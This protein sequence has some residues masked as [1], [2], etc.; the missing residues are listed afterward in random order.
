[1]INSEI[2]TGLSDYF[3]RVD[4]EIERME[5]HKVSRLLEYLNVP[6]YSEAF[7]SIEKV[8]K[9]DNIG[10]YLPESIFKTIDFKALAIP[11]KVTFHC[12]IHDGRIYIFNQKIESEFPYPAKRDRLSYIKDFNQ[13]VNIKFPFYAADFLKDKLK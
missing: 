8:L 7:I 4:E 6:K 9:W 5:N 12:N 3:K 10:V 13:D 2:I 11:K 1:M